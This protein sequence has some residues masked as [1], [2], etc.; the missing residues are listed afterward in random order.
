MAKKIGIIKSQENKSSVDKIIKKITVYIDNKKCNID[1]V[2]YG[3]Y[4]SQKFDLIIMPLVLTTP[5]LFGFFDEKVFESVIENNSSD[6]I[7]FVIGLLQRY[8]N[9]LWHKDVIEKLHIKDLVHVCIF[10]DDEDFQDNKT[11]DKVKKIFD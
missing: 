11:N 8:F 9:G 4:D 10:G 2:E 7:V 5:R 1:I 6:K 3:K